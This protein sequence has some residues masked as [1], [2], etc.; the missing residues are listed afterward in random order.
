MPATSTR[1]LRGPSTRRAVLLT[2]HFVADQERA[3][4]LGEIHR[5]LKPG[6]PFVAMQL[7]FEQSEPARS[8]WLE[9]YVAFAVSSG[10]DPE[11]AKA[12][13]ATIGAQVP[14]LSPSRDE[15]LMRGAGFSDVEVFYTGLAFRGWVGARLSASPGG[16]IVRV[17]P[18]ALITSSLLVTLLTAGCSREPR[19]IF[20]VQFKCEFQGLDEPLPVA[21]DLERMRLALQ[22]SSDSVIS[23]PL[24][25][26]G[27]QLVF[28]NDP[29]NDQSP[30]LW[31]R[32]DGI[33]KFR[34]KLSPAAK[35]VELPGACRRTT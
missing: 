10:V 9:R 4:T 32:R 30:K 21:V 25:N 17:L 5:R 7:S 24:N 27:G 11:K 13:A 20:L 8:R 34:T 31:M 15:E 6:A 18:V 23:V 19:N 16:E 28:E 1:R 26:V 14:V 22:T 33:A 3:R 2:L 35:A 29:R 12:A